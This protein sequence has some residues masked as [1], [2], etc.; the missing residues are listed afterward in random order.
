M[1]RKAMFLA[2][3]SGLAVFSS[4]AANLD[5]QELSNKKTIALCKDATLKDNTLSIQRKELPSSGPKFRGVQFKLD[6][7]KLGAC[8]K[9][10]QI[11]G[12]IKFDNVS[13]PPQV[14][15]GVKAMLSYRNQGKMEYPSC[16]KGISYGS[17]DW[18]PFT[19]TIAIPAT[20]GQC[21]LSLGLQDSTGT[22]SFRNIKI[23]V[24]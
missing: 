18:T 24:K 14:W 4:E 15:N 7:A 5:F 13:R 20:A 2:L 6:L 23:D 8:G 9:N 11:S 12:E 22:V 21:T 10:L 1:N 19:S 16:Y 17:R 3:I